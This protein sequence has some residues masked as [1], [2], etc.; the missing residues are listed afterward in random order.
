MDH[1]QR[2]L[3][4]MESDRR[5]ER[6]PLLMAEIKSALVNGSV[7]KPEAPSLAAS[8]RASGSSKAV[9]KTIGG[10]GFLSSIRTRRRAKP[11]RPERCT[12]EI[13]QS[14]WMLAARKASAEL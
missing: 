5:A 14:G 3:S 1:E 8:A 12:A 13:M 9:M 2:G 4:S 10:G 11:E 7:R 6:V